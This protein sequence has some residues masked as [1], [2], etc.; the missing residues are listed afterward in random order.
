[1]EIQIDYFK[2]YVEDLIKLF[3]IIKQN[4]KEKVILKV[5]NVSNLFN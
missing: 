1:M 3:K 5:E 2:A 4:K